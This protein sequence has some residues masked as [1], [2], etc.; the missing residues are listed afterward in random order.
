[1]HVHLVLFPDTTP[2]REKRGSGDFK[3]VSSSLAFTCILHN[4]NIIKD[5]VKQS[6]SSNVIQLFLCARGRACEQG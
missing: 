3:I 4:H 5:S 2:H 6:V 1:M